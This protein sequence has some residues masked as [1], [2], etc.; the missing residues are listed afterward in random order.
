MTE[1]V[2]LV[3]IDGSD[4]GQ[5]AL[6]WAIR[7]AK[8]LGWPMRLVGAY[9]VPNVATTGIDVS[10]VPMD[11]ESIRDGVRAVV[12]DALAKARSEGL[13]AEGLVEV[14]D[15]AGVLVE[16]SKQSG[17]AVVG[18]RGK[19][20]FAGRFLGTVSSALPAHSECPTVIVPICW[21]EGRQPAAETAEGDDEDMD[22]T[23]RI[24]T[25]IDALGK[26]NPALW[27][28]AESAVR[29]NKPLSIV[30]V[31]SLMVVGPEWLPA[32]IDMERYQ[33]EAKA[34]LGA[35]VDAL[36][37]KYPSLDVEWELFEGSPAEM[38]IRASHTADQLVV[39]SRGRGGF[40][41]LLLGSTSQAVLHH[42]K[43]P[44]MVVRV[45]KKDRSTVK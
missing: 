30:G 3:G 22:F 15:A 11:D 40:A 10:Y 42:A 12:D 7:E 25:G 36:N 26:T 34:S 38:L 13:E 14:G 19:G 9:S 29:K 21:A 32:G 16:E 44:V 2:V 1:N 17:L 20:G 41:G 45:N 43:C 33:E 8:S 23:G 28:A 24:V 31:M 18:S 35:C 4:T 5:C 39:G 37:E 6:E 27:A